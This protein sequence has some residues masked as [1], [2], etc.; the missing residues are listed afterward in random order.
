MRLD[1][2]RFREFY[3]QVATI[4]LW[5]EL[6]AAIDA[7]VIVAV[8]SLLRRQL[9]DAAPREKRM[10]L[11]KF[12]VD[13]LG[14]VLRLTGHIGRETPFQS[15]GVDSLMSLE[16]RNRLETDLG[17]R[18]PS[19]LLFTYTDLASLSDHLLAQ[20]APPE[21]NVAENQTAIEVKNIQVAAPV[22][23]EAGAEDFLAAFDASMNALMD[24][25]AT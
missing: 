13:Q 25:E 11:E 19:T 17:L 9:D 5:A 14:R 10:V 18:L 15:L 23:P 16:L 1:M 6:N 7:D 21:T 2:R 24:T 4:P 8:R 20:L 3:P 12:L 22:I